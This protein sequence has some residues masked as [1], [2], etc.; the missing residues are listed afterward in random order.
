M[1]HTKEPWKA[2]EYQELSNGEKLFQLIAS[3]PNALRPGGEWGR[4]QGEANAARIVACINGCT[5]LNPA[6][7]RSVVEA[8]RDMLTNAYPNTDN[9]SKALAHALETT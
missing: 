9:A 4:I 3:Q 8:L 1:S 6:A 2:T 7:Y 5:G